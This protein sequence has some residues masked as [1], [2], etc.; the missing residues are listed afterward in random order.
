M[1]V[2]GVVLALAAVVAV[3][4]AAPV[5][6]DE[7]P[8]P[9]HQKLFSRF[10]DFW[11][12]NWVA[13]YQ[14]LLAGAG[15]L[16]VVVSVLLQVGAEK[17]RRAAQDLADMRAALLLISVAFDDLSYALSPKYFNPKNEP[18]IGAFTHLMA[19]A[20]LN[21]SFAKLLNT[22]WKESVRVWYKI[23]KAERPKGWSQQ[24]QREPDIRRAIAV[25]SGWSEYLTG[26]VDLKY[27]PRE[28]GH[29]KMRC[30]KLGEKFAAIGIDA[31]EMTGMQH[32]IILE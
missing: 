24:A 5:W 20:R 7:Y 23:E 2:L 19:V 28:L 32:L 21:P 10:V 18:D 29:R 31:S 9:F 16:G 26:A 12:F 22:F 15:A 17:R 30:P 8:L 1:R 4:F 27:S 6:L 14:T 25:C 13:E 11:R 3:L